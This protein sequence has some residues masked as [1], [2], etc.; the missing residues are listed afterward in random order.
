MKNHIFL[1][2]G[3]DKSKCRN[4]RMKLQVIALPETIYNATNLKFIHLL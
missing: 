4:A 2:V 1:A 3:K